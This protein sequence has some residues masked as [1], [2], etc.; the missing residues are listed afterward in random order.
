M[1]RDNTIHYRFRRSAMESFA[2]L[3]LAAGKGKRM[4]SECPK[5]LHK[6]LGKSLIEHVR[7]AACF[8]NVPCFC[9]ISRDQRARFES[10]LAGTVRFCYQERPRGTA[11][12]VKSALPVLS[13]EKIK[14]VLVCP[15]DM[16]LLKKQTLSRLIRRHERQGNAV[17]MLTGILE[18][19]RHY[20]RVLR[21][22]SGRCAAVVEEKDLEKGMKTLNEVNLGVYVFEVG[23]LKRC[24]SRI[25]AQNAQKEFYLTDAVAIAAEMSR[26]KKGAGAGSLCVGESDECLG[27]NSRRDLARAIEALRLRKIELLMDKGVTIVDP[28]STFID[29]HV[30]VGKDTVI[31]PFC[32]ISGRVRIG[33]GCEIG[34]FAH[35]RQGVRLEEGACVGNFVEIKQ[36]RLGKGAKAKHLTYL[37]NAKIGRRVNIGAGTITANYDGVRKHETVLKNGCKIGANTVIVAPNTLGRNI[38]TGAGTVIPANQKIPSGATVYGVPARVAKTHLTRSAK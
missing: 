8:R 2:T 1:I 17:T 32:V 22:E 29:S 10:S 30:T 34:P 19:P 12:A 35:L 6:A 15:G 36:S 27:I 4:K 21:D 23:F 24:L 25:R 9:V 18:D 37:G 26:E 28:S 5:V 38:T 20:G 3:I 16:P 11:D 13:R 31:H 14:K 7:D 33:K